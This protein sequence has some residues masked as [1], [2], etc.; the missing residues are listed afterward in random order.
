MNYKKNNFFAYLKPWNRSE[1]V[2]LELLIRPVSLRA[3]QTVSHVS[4]VCQPA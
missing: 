3:H 4:G 2:D 1:I